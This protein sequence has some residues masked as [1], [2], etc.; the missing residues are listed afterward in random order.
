MAWKLNP[1][2]DLVLNL[3][4]RPSGKPE[5]VDVAV[6]LFFSDQPPTLFPMLLQLEHDG[7]IDIPPGSRSFTVTD[8]LKLPVDV[9]LLAIY[10]HAH[11]LG[12]QVEA[13]ADLPGGSR[14][15]LLKINDWNIDWQATY[16]YKNPVALPAGTSLGM[17]ITYDN[18]SQ[19]P[20]NPNHPPKR[21]K[22]GDR[23]EDEMGHVWLQ[24]L[25]RRD[26]D[27]DPR[28]LLQQAA[29]QRRIEKYPADFEA[30]F[31]LGAALQALNR[32]DEAIAYL[33]RA[34]K[35]RPSSAMARNNLAVS[36]LVTDRIDEAIGGFREALL[37]D[38]GITTRG[39]I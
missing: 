15:P 26:S 27:A 7:A 28:L 29:M 17:R 21:V 9:Q 25:P 31:N 34:A 2:S 18:S 8:H 20:R 33:S 35:I 24:V 13:W 23:G 37:L 36:L 14:R 39:S 5:T 3:H 30:H 19:N 1:G 4:L 10:P 22:D 11:Y 38:P 12:K 6:G 16:T 32:H